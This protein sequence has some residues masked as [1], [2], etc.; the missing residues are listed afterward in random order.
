MSA[1]E[2]SG[3]GADGADTGHPGAD[4]ERASAARAFLG[5]LQRDT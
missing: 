5:L 3:A 4:T 1:T 2:R